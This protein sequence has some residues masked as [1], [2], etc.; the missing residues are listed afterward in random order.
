MGR[1]VG[2][3]KWTEGTDGKRD[4][5]QEKE[6]DTES[7]EAVRDIRSSPGFNARGKKERERERKS[8]REGDS[9]EKMACRL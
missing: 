2:Q 1:M 7:M 5:A 4:G 3:E 6:S 8:E 9:E